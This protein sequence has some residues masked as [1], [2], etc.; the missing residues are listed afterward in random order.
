MGQSL[1]SAS[2]LN[3]NYLL[4]KNPAWRGIRPWQLRKKRKNQ[5]DEES[6][7]VA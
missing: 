4:P 7:A 6:F 5:S 3:L 2:E 1:K